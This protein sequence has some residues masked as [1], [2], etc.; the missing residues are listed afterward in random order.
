MTVSRF[1]RGPVRRGSEDGARYVDLDVAV[2]VSSG[3]YVRALARDLGAALGVGGHLTALR[4]TRVAGFDVE[5]ATP[6]DDLTAAGEAGR[7]LPVIP[8]ARAATGALASRTASVD[9]ARDLGFGRRIART[10]RDGDPDAASPLAVLD[11]AGSL[12]ALVVADGEVLRP[13]AVFAA[14]R[15]GA[16]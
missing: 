10:E 6:L 1:E 12:L 14:D 3:T 9:E 7:A 16:P 5:D 8:L 4:R 11:A 13:I 15:M 2:T